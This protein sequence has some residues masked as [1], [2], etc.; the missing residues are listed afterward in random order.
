M[1]GSVS[2]GNYFF[3]NQKVS[4]FQLNPRCKHTP[5]CHLTFFSQT[6]GKGRFSVKTEPEQSL[7]GSVL[8]FQNISHALLL[9]VNMSQLLS[10][11]HSPAFYKPIVL[12]WAHTY[13]IHSQW[14]ATSQCRWTRRQWQ[15][16]HMVWLRSS[17]PVFHTITFLAM[18]P[19]ASQLQHECMG[20]MLSNAFSFFEWVNACSRGAVHC[21]AFSFIS[22]FMLII[23]LS[24]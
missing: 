24:P 6:H 16:V 12:P 10:C 15:I 4:Y 23:P 2:S 11:A 3:P 8:T 18:L 21:T 13:H 9:Q 5:K 19:F 7:L 20:L 14:E 22:H 1:Y 17:S